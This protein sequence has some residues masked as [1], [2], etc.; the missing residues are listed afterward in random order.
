MQRTHTATNT[1]A[2][3]L[4]SRATIL[5]PADAAE[6]AAAV[7]RLQVGGGASGAHRGPE[8]IRFSALVATATAAT[9]SAAAH[10]EEASEVPDTAVAAQTV[11]IVHRLE[12]V[13][14]ISRCA[15]HIHVHV[16]IIT[17]V[18]KHQLA[19]QLQLQHGH[20]LGQFITRAAALVDRVV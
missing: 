1:T 3:Q 4:G 2:Q 7:A 15:I 20:K 11:Q 5:T 17:L 8:N 19:V 12:E 9:N 16:H 13:I 6:E 18:R 10:A 14:I